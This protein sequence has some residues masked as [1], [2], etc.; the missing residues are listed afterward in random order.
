M[1]QLGLWWPLSMLFG[2]AL[3][4]R[5]L[6]V[7]IGWDDASMTGRMHADKRLDYL[8]QQHEEPRG[9]GLWLLACR[10]TYQQRGGGPK[11]G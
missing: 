1:S 3:R 11:Y 2:A 7:R 6:R 9:F 10:M 4:L 8:K 5:Q